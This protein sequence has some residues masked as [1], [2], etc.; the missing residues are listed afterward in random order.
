ML[1]FVENFLMLKHVLAKKVNFFIL[2]LLYPTLSH[3]IKLAINSNN[4]FCHNTTFDRN[5]DLSSQGWSY[6][7]PASKSQL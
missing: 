3:Q 4:A 5:E 7:R 1:P 6:Q 2:F